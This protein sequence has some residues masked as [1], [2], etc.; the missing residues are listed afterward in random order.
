MMLC[1]SSVV[2]TGVVL[3]LKLISRKPAV[4]GRMKVLNVV[5][6]FVNVL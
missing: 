4:E 1:V 3:W 5:T 2:L 6:V